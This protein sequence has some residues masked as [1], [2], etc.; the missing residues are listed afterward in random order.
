MRAKMHRIWFNGN[1][2]PDADAMPPEVRRKYEAAL[3]RRHEAEEGRSSEVVR[4]GVWDDDEDGLLEV[5]TSQEIIV[6]GKKYSDFD[7]LPASEREL[8]RKMLGRFPDLT[9]QIGDFEKLF[10]EDMSLR[11]LESRSARDAERGSGRG[12]REVLAEAT[13]GLSRSPFRE[14]KGGSASYWKNGWAV[15]FV[16][17]IA[18]LWVLV[19][20]G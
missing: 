16:L 11:R 5:H 1:G 19:A 8:V 3:E 7:Q 17:A 12:A 18:L 13:T 9:G 14:Q 20:R 4:M 2:Y 10:D 15:A 6:N